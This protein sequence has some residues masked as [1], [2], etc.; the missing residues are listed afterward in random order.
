MQEYFVEKII[1]ACKCEHSMQYLVRWL[2]YGPEE[3]QWLPC[4][5]LVDNMALDDWLAETQ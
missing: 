5:K 1:D 2:G 3:D 4:S